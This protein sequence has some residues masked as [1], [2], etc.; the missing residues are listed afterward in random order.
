MLANAPKGKPVLIFV[1]AYFL[2]KAFPL[3]VQVQTLFSVLLFYVFV[4]VSHSA[5]I[6]SFD[7]LKFIS[8]LL[9]QIITYF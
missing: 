4:K 6:Q 5:L 2:F 3:S 7:Y 9:Q 8:V 1:I